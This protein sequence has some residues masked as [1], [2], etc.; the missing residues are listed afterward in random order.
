MPGRAP[1][2]VN[3][4]AG[5][6]THFALAGWLRMIERNEEAINTLACSMFMDELGADMARWSSTKP[7]EKEIWRQRA[8]SALYAL[9]QMASSGVR[10]SIG[11]ALP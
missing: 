5:A 10:R 9:G 8:R 6:A 2:I 4:L 7:A 1:S 11:F 3:Q